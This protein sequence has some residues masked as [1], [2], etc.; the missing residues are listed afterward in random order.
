M[1]LFAAIERKDCVVWGIGTST[2][3]AMRDAKKNI[4]SQPQF[5]VGKLE[6]AVLDEKA[7]PRDCSEG[8]WPH[9]VFIPVPA[10]ESLF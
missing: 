10:Q 4:A 7:D 5:Q 9:V 8:L 3:A 2:D 6:I 1:S